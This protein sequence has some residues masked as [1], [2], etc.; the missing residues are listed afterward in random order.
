MTHWPA[1][2]SGRPF[3]STG[4]TA[5]AEELYKKS[6][7]MIDQSNADKSP[8][9]REILQSY[10]KLLYRLSRL[11]EANDVYAPLRHQQHSDE[12]C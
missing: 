8:E 11:I 1:R 4:K 10:A 6:I 2:A 3:V 5:G 12:T 7:G 9:I